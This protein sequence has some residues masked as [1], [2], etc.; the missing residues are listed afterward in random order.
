MTPRLER[1]H[2]SIEWA[3]SG[4]PVGYETALAIMADRAAAIRD[5][6]AAEL[7]WLLEHPPLYTA[8]T[9]ANPEHLLEPNRLPVFQA[10]RGGQYTYHGPG[11]RVVYIMLDLKRRGGDVR[12]LVADLERWIIA[13]LATF[14]VKGE[15]RQGRVGI[16]VRRPDQ[17]SAGEDKIAAIG[18]RVSRWVTTHGISLNVE[19]DLRHYRGIVPCGIS[20]QGVTSLTDL[21][22]PVTMADA[23]V[24]LRHSFE[25][26]FGQVR[27]VSATALEV[28]A[29]TSALTAI[30]APTA[31][32]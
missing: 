18:L 25:A 22:L 13:T 7:I 31:A 14:N 9:S 8:G 32:R 12:A 16:W 20:D 17:R 3:V 1:A 10:G 6:G 21:G 30:A 5:A 27:P 4:T 19:P 24:A 23:D 2:H 26:V 28:G 11:Q 29:T 15:T